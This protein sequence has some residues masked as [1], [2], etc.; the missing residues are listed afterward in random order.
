MSSSVLI[1]I[2]YLLLFWCEFSIM[3][4][5]NRWDANKLFSLH[6]Y[7]NAACLKLFEP[8]KILKWTPRH[9]FVGFVFDE[10]S[11]DLVSEL[12]RLL[13]HCS[14]CIHITSAEVWSLLVDRLPNLV[15]KLPSLFQLCKQYKE[16]YYIF[17]ERMEMDLT[18]IIRCK[19]KCQ[20]IRIT[21]S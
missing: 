2:L 6:P 9:E 1:A 10:G 14:A 19:I 16:K 3:F 7:L 13:A 21:K 18:Y 8:S 17:Y 20:K 11:G 15:I 4:H 5:Q 12:N